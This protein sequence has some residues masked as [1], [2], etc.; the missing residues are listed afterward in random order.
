MNVDRF[1]CDV[2]NGVQV[3]QR[4]GQQF[5]EMPATNEQYAASARLVSWLCSV[6][7]VRCDREHVRTHNEAS[8]RDGHVLCCVGALDP[9]RVV[10]MA[11]KV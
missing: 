6:L 11:Q 2:E 8:P 9:D 4:P 5:V 1:D 10:S 7:K 3:F